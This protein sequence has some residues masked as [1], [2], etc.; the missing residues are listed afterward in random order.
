MSWRIEVSR[1]AR[2]E[3]K[4]IRDK[5]LKARIVAAIDALA[6]DPRPPGVAK[7]AGHRDLWR[8]RVGDWRVVYR[9]EDGALLVLVAAS[10]KSARGS[11]RGGT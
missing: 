3:L 9:V 8:V 6:D 1:A 10:N 7:L 5:T 2:K 4:A 11:L